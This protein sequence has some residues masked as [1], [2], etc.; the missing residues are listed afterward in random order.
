MLF[1]TRSSYS[2]S[3]YLETIGFI[4]TVLRNYDFDLHISLLITGR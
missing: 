1:H 2:V 3:I 4:L